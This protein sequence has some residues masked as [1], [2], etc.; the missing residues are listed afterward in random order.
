MRYLGTTLGLGYLIDPRVQGTIT[1][2]SPQPVPKDVV[3]GVVEDVL[4]MNGAALVKEGAIYKIVPIEEANPPPIILRQEGRL[5][6]YRSRLQPQ[7]YT[8]ALCLR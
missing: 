2:R 5:A 3:I 6:A 8:V 7:Y 4:A 1:V